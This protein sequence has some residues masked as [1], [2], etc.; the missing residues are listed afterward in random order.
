MVV[1][2]TAYGMVTFEGPLLSLK[3]VNWISHY[4]DWTIAHV[5]VGGLGWNGMLAFGMFYYLVPKMWNT[6]LY[7][8]GLAN[9]HFWIATLGI[10]FYAIPIYWGGFYQGL[11]WK[12]FDS[13]GLIAHTFVETLVYLKPFWLM[14]ALGGTMYFL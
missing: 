9:A 1:A 6:K 8:R 3:N 2:I 11:M 14:R 4:T 7:S 13:D 5:H 10:L 12:Q